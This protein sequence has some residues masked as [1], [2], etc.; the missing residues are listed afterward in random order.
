VQ[1]FVRMLHLGIWGQL[2]QMGGQ[3]VGGV[4][5]QHSPLW[6]TLLIILTLIT[7]LFAFY[8]GKG[9]GGCVI[10][11][12]ALFAVVLCFLS[13]AI[14]LHL[15]GQVGAVIVAVFGVVAFFIGML[16]AIDA[17]LVGMERW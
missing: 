17:G 2:T 11:A 16:R 10:D 14:S 13:F 15:L 8:G 7:V 6:D 5:P 1:E 4:V 3:M 9:I 12:V